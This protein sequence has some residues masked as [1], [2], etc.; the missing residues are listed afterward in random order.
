[1]FL[2]LGVVAACSVAYSQIPVSGTINGNFITGTVTNVNPNSIL[3][4]GTII[5]VTS[6]AGSGNFMVV[7]VPSN[8]PIGNVSDAVNIINNTFNSFNVLGALVGGINPRPFGSNAGEY[9]LNFIP[10]P[11]QIPFDFGLS[12]VLGAG[13]IAAVKRARQRR[14]LDETIA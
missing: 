6:T 7:T 5:T 10:P 14:K 11:T 2:A 12:A 3:I 9:S 8:N 4:V 1:M 13:A